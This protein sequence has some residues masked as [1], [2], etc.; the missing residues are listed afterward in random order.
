MDLKALQK[1]LRT[2]LA[3]NWDDEQLRTRLER[4]GEAEENVS[5][6]TWPWA[7]ELYQRNRRLF[8]PLILLRFGRTV[9]TGRFTWKPAPVRADRARRPRTLSR[10]S[11]RRRPL[12]PAPPALGLGR[13]QM[14]FPAGFARRRRPRRKLPLEPLPSVAP[15]FS[16]N[17]CVPLALVWL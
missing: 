2:L 11:A 10:R 3:Q 14:S 1:A 7:P 17:I 6:L 12:H 8:R 5:G 13:G 16:Y 15:H 4:L 9:R